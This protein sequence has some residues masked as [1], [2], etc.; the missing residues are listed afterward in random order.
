MKERKNI[1]RLF[2]EKFKD[3]EAMPPEDAWANIEAKLDGKK[4]KRIIP[5]WWKL[6]GVAAVL[7]LGFLVSKSFFDDGIKNDNPIV[8]ENN[9]LKKE[10][11]NTLDSNKKA[12]QNNSVV[13]NKNAV[14]D[15]DNTN[16]A[17]GK[18]LESNTGAKEKGL[19]TI[20]NKGALKPSADAV[21]TTSNEA[22]NNVSPEEKRNRRIIH[23]SKS[24]VAER[25]SSHHPLK[26]KSNGE[27][28]QANPGESVLGKPQNQLAQN[29]RNAAQ[30]NQNT[31]KAEKGLAQ[32]NTAKNNKE[33]QNTDDKKN[34]NLDALKGDINSKV[35]TKETDKKVNDTTS[36]TSVAKNELEEL[37]NEKESKLKKE[38]KLN[39]WQLAS[40]VAPVFLGSVSNG[41]PL[42]PSLSKNAKSYNTSVGY[43][44]GV[45]YAVNKKISIRT[46]LN[47]VSLSYN[48]ND[49][50]FFTGIQ[51]KTLT[52][53]Q[54]TAESAM[55]HVESNTAN[56]NTSL[57]PEEG[58]LPFGTSISHKNSGYLR[59]E[60]GYIEM[61]VEMTYNLLDR[62]F[63]VK[64]I[65]G[66][67]T[68]FLQ[69]NSIMIVS[70]GHDTTLG[71]ANNLNDVHFSTNFGLGMKYNFMKSFEFN[72]EPTFKYQ[73]NTYNSNAGNFKPYIFGIYSGI[74]YKF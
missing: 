68:F 58:L 27:Q 19:E 10:G 43:G 33:I 12:S 73:L 66:F 4:K 7:L 36:K 5:F 15:Q 39:R 40:N 55:I 31:N 44:I 18:S 11:S 1:D 29:Q 13:E 28:H 72:V 71:E 65:G 54:P 69:D 30:E 9:T 70:E 42:D 41:S 48:T 60:M 25:K 67:S 64:L 17:E 22:K 35:A 14:A 38:S 46:G 63:G 26:N 74:S 16:A 24:A 6:S 49:I 20:K 51:S 52:N 3:F 21:A 23:S 47:K 50:S 53:V 2:Q 34:I 61:P 32:D 56:A 8:N 45:G 57:S 37:L 62:K 59:Q